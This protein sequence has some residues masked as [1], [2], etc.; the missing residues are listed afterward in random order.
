MK[1]LIGK[2]CVL[3]FCFFCLSTTKDEPH[4]W[5]FILR[6]GEQ[7]TTRPEQVCIVTQLQGVNTF[8]DMHQINKV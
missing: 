8:A 5:I 4:L 1:V 6:F 2:A 7:R 3:G